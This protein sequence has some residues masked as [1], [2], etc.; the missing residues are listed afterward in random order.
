ML[1][2]IRWL[3]KENGTNFSSL[4]KELNFANGSLVKFGESTKCIRVYKLA[5]H[6]GVSMEWLVSGKQVE[7]ILDNH[8]KNL[9]SMYRS[10]NK[11]G[12]AELLKMADIYTR[13]PEYQ[14]GETLYDSDIGIAN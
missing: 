4:E 11:D 12:R 1:E 3:C 9:I 2:R 5:Q 8:E 10:L 14:M 6:F 13:L 7:N